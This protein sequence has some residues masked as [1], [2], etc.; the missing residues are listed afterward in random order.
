MNAF[1]TDLFHSLRMADFF[2]I[3]IISVLIYLVLI[4]FEATASRFVLLGIFILGVVYIMARL[5]HMYL[6][7]VVLQAFF[8]ISLFALVVIFQEEL[9]RF[10][11]RIS[12]WGIMRKSHSVVSGYPEI[13]VISRT[14]NNLARKKVGALV[15]V[16]GAD[17]LDRHLEGGYDL[18]GRLSEP[19]LESIFDPHSLGHD[20]AAI[21][22]SGRLSKF[23]CHLPLSNNIRAL[24]MRGTRHSAALGLA[25]RTDALV[26]AVSEERGTISL[27]KE[28]RLKELRDPKS[29][30]AELEKYYLEK[31]PKRHRS[32]SQWLR[33]KSWEKAA[34]VI[35]SCVLW[36][37]FIYQTGTVRRDFAVPIEYRNLRADWLVEEPKPNEIT[38]TLLGRARAFDLLDSRALKVVV[39]MSQIKQ[40]VQELALPPEAVSHPS[41]LSVVSIEPEKIRVAA[42]QLVETNLPVEVQTHGKTPAGYK[43]SRVEVTPVSIPMLIPSKGWN[44]SLKALTESIDLRT[45]TE[46]TTV[47]PSLI[48][49]NGAR[50][51]GPKPPK[52]DVKVEVTK[53]ST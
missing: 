34:A 8:A 38:V 33:E 37:V 23:G 10:F 16:R 20:G 48:L 24:G 3:A 18:D 15:V 30:Q 17:P 21:V 52:V 42:Y 49:P 6:T 4:W 28:E 11:E 43:V 22:E 7:A 41:S 12:I 27:A 36:F 51:I 53:T 2:D 29:L 32:W 31:F 14:L 19:L 44:G 9:R 25:E 1:F 40:G 35:V 50:P 45:L 47:S 46:T 26:I 5:F 39:D 13:D